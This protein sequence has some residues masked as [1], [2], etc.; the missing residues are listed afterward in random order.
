MYFTNPQQLIDMCAQLEA[1]N[2]FML[3]AN[4]ASQEASMA[5]QATCDHAEAAAA[6]QRASLQE[7]VDMLQHALEQEQ[8]KLA[9]MVVDHGGDVCVCLHIVLTTVIFTHPGICGWH[10]ANPTRVARGS[11]RGLSMLWRRGRASKHTGDAGNHRGACRCGVMYEQA[12]LCVLLTNRPSSNATWLHVRCS[13]RM[14][15][16]QKSGPDK[17]SGEQVHVRQHCYN[18]AQSRYG[19]IVY[20]RS[21]SEKYEQKIIHIRHTQERR[22]QRVLQ[23]AEEQPR[24]K[25]KIKPK[26]VRSVLVRSNGAQQRKHGDAASQGVDANSAR[27][28]EYVTGPVLL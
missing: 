22:V 23:R 5:A 13:P 28:E 18:S 14:W 4:Q 17:H 27:V 16:R 2:L 9:H 3:Q 20:H 6:A 12:S 26:M 15:L 10:C 21:S 8:A 11:A 24:V 1:S 19:C 7:Q 25:A